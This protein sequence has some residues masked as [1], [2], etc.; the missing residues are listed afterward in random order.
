MITSKIKVG[1]KAIGDGE[2]VF[3]IAEAG[4]N[5][6]GKL[7][8]AEKLIERAAEVGADAIKFQ[9]FKAQEI[10][11]CKS[12]YYDSF[13]SLEFSA[14]EWMHLAQMAK[15]MGLIFT[16]S[17]FG[18]ESADILDTLDLPL[19]KIASGDITF[20]QLL[21]YVARKNK[22]ILL[23]TGM[24][25][26]GEIEEAV[27]VI[28]NA[29]N[30]KII[31]LHCISSYPANYEELNLRTI[32]TLKKT[33]NLPVGFSDH[34]SGIVA[35]VIAVTLGANVIEKHFTLDKNLAGPDH[36]FSSD[37]VEFA[38]IVRSIRITEKA[39]GNGIKRP[40][41]SEEKL[42]RH[43][44][45]SLFARTA[46]PKGT[47]ITKDDVKTVRPMDGID[48]RF[49]DLVIG[50]MAKRDIMKDEPITWDDIC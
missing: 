28:L 24:A 40:T 22:P 41:E 50:R 35:P 14:K 11:S 32:Q 3:I 25:M 23:S 5:H 17:V 34:S 2:P 47:I 26:L 48:P 43:A 38:E 19:I 18:R 4:I 27:N 36:K 29:G 31:L 37:P 10:C 42:K 1:N 39:L 13:K 49:I 8:L 45:R 20:H 21:D 16:A 9:I 44:R 7:N 6:N 12:I 46:I 15:D 30:N 33:F